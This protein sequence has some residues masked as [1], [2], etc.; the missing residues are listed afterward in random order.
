MREWPHRLRSVLSEQSLVTR[1]MDQHPRTGHN[2]GVCDKVVVRTL[3]FKVEDL[4]LAV[5]RR[6]SD[7]L[8]EGSSVRT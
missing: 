5:V 4:E 8:G 2:V 3:N 7:D 6:R 1:I